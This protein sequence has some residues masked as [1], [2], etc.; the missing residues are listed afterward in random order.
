MK[1][2]ALNSRSLKGICKILT[3]SIFT[4]SFFYS[5]G[6]AC[7]NTY[8]G[9]AANWSALTWSCGGAGSAAPTTTGTYNENLSVGTIGNGGNLT[10]NITFTL[11]GTLTVSSS[12]SNPTI[13]IPAGVTVIINGDFLDND[14]NVRFDVDGT[15]VV[16]GKLKAKNSAVFSGSGSI[17]GGELELGNGPSCSGAC[18]GLSFQVCDSGDPAF[19]ANVTSANTYTWDGSSSTAWGTAA[20]WTPNRGTPAA[21]DVLIFSASGA[22]KNI[23]LTA[24]Q[25]IG[26]IIVTGSST[27]SFTSSAAR[28]LTLTSLENQ[29]LTIDNGSTLSV[30]NASYTMGVTL[31]T[32]GSASIGGQLNLVNG[33]FAVG[34]ATLQLHTNSTPLLRTSGQVTM[35][36]SAVLQFGAAGLTTGSTIVL[37]DNIFATPPTI[38][39]VVLNRSNGATL[40][41]QPITVESTA[42]FTLGNLNTNAAGRLKFGT[43]ATSPVESGTSKIIGYAEM[44]SRSVG[45][46]GTDFLDMN[47]AAGGDNIGSL[48]I[49]RRTGSNGR[50]VFNSNE[51]ISVSWDVTATTNPAAGRT[52]L[53]RWLPAFDN[54]ATSTLRFQ[55]Y[56]SSGGGGWATLGSLQLLTA[57]NPKRVTG[58]STTT[59]LNNTTFTVADETQT[60]P[61]NLVSFAGRAHA[62]EVML[63]WK[64]GSEKD[65]DF[66]SVEKMNEEQS[67]YAIGKVTGAGNSTTGKEYSFIDSEPKSG[68]NYY[69]LRQVDFNGAFSYSKVIS[70]TFEGEENSITVYPNPVESGMLFFNN[71]EEPSMVYIRDFSGKVL[72][73]VIVDP[74]DNKASLAIG[75]YQLAS[76]LYHLTIVRPGKP[77]TVTKLVID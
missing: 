4:F 27:Y 7:S 70:V 50:N 44:N 77:Y 9:G 29:A 65:N 26:K 6:Q 2:L 69:R 68:I 52:I 35:G 47:V 28:V 61:V 76:G 30:G 37:P 51:S 3:Y 13:T 18:P 16:T 46:G 23:V 54:I 58:S 63:S 38:S 42:T 1:N 64:T 21:S 53:F 73:Q 32:N 10:M 71:M 34:S 41:D 45:F 5:N 55:K 25:S 75:D 72:L 56:M 74:K 17:S 39:S 36:S 49:V 60:L 43:A 57:T 24:N 31:P 15:L 66:F 22:N 67:F 40:G 12:G 33:N 11:N 59:T 62:A 8:P 14:N 20:N 48:R 19:C